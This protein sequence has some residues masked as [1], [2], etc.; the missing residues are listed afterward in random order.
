MAIWV[1]EDTTTYLGWS[2]E[3]WDFLLRWDDTWARI[4][5]SLSVGWD[6]IW[7]PRALIEDEFSYL[8]DEDWYF[9]TDT[10]GSY[11]I[12]PTVAHWTEWR[13]APRPGRNQTI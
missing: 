2:W 7:I 3:A 8:I 11:I 6:T 4:I 9:I 13:P 5:A 12:I 1:I 10:N